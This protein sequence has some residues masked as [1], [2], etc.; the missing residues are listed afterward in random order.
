M[1]NRILIIV[2][3]GAIFFWLIWANLIFFAHATITGFHIEKLGVWGDSFG[4]LNAFFSA[5]AFVAVLRTLSVQS[6]E[7]ALQNERI[8]RSDMDAQLEQFE[9]N[10]FQ[11]LEL[12]RDLR[13]RLAFANGTT[14]AEG[15]EVF[16][17]ATRILTADLFFAE[18]LPPPTNEDIRNFVSDV[19]ERQIHA[20]GEE[21]LGTYFRVLYT[22]LRR[23]SE[24]N[25]LTRKQKDQYGNLVRSQLSSAEVSIIAANSLTAA[26]NNMQTYVEEFRLLKY[27]PEGRYR[28][29]MKRLYKP[30]TFEARD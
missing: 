14:S 1:S 16:R 15:S 7:I 18:M 24:N 25:V 22:N 20:Y 11:L 13:E 4:G 23:I 5:A 27:M 26:S 8:N 28:E 10:F 19:Y 17:I 12:L 9:R 2:A 3:A 30:E 29:W 6:R 21:S